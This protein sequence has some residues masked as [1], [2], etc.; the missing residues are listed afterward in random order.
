MGDVCRVE[1]GLDKQ[2]A[3]GLTEINR[4]AAIQVIAFREDRPE[5][6][7]GVGVHFEAARPDGRAEGRQQ[8]SRAAAVSLTHRRNRMRCNARSRAAPAGMDRSH[9]SSRR[10][11]QQDGNTIGG[12][13]GD[14]RGGGIRCQGVGGKMGLPFGGVDDLRAVHLVEDEKTVSGRGHGRTERMG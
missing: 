7:S 11:G 2:S 4:G 14:A 6:L 1:A 9:N 5:V 8:V 10:I 3:I 13:H 12:F